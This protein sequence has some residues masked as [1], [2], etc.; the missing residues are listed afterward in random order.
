MKR[1]LMLL[2]CAAL[3]SSA[4]CAETLSGSAPAESEIE[5]DFSLLTP[6]N[7]A[8]TPIPVDPID[9]PTPTPM[10]KPNFHYDT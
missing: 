8:A 4:A 5:L 6:D 2:L 3:L 9:K 10:P 7:P 1:F